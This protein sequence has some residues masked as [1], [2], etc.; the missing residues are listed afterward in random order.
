MRVVGDGEG[1]GQRRGEKPAGPAAHT[2]RGGGL[3]RCFIRDVCASIEA[4]AAMVPDAVG[5]ARRGP[6]CVHAGRNGSGLRWVWRRASFA[7]I[8]QR[9]EGLGERLINVADDLLRRDYESVAMMNSDSPTIPAAILAGAVANLARPGDHIAIVGADDGGYCLI[10]LKRRHWR[11]FEDIAWSTGGGLRTDA[12]AGRESWACEAA[13][14]PSWYDVDD[15]AA[16]R[17]LVGELFGDR[18]GQRN[19]R[20]EIRRIR[21]TRNSRLADRRRSLG[22]LAGR[23]GID[24]RATPG[25]RPSVVAT[26]RRGTRSFV[27]IESMPAARMRCPPPKCMIIRKRGGG[28]RTYKDDRDGGAGGTGRAKAMALAAQLCAWIREPRPRADRRR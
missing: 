1:A 21:G 25:P 14:L 10:G 28:E 5:C 11:I 24:R 17:R 8:E 19:H 16:L 9:G 26:R 13:R 3:N 27:K 2:G 23:L 22:G 7:L 18:L 15:A 4:A 12:G 20:T 6:D